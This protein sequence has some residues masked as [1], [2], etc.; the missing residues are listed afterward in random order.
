MTSYILFFFLFFG[1]FCF[2]KINDWTRKVPDLTNHTQC[3][4]SYVVVIIIV[5]CIVCNVLHVVLHDV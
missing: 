4:V 3:I 2:I 1:N 5:R